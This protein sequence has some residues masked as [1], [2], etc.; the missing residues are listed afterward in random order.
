MKPKLF[1]SHAWE[2]E[3]DFVEPLATALRKEGFD[4]WYDKFSLKLGDSLLEKIGEGLRQADFGVVV[5][6]PSFFKMK[7]PRSELSGLVALETAEHKVVLPIWKDVNHDEVLGYSPVLGDRVAVLASVGIPRVV[8]EIKR[9]IGIPD[10]DKLSQSKLGTD[11]P[12]TVQ[13]AL[14]QARAICHCTATGEVMLLSSTLSGDYVYRCSR[15][16]RRQSSNLPNKFFMMVGKGLSLAATP[17]AAAHSSGDTPQR[18]GSTLS[19]TSRK[20]SFVSLPLRQPAT[21][22]LPHDGPTLRSRPKRRNFRRHQFP[23]SRKFP[24]ALVLASIA[25]QARPPTKPADSSGALKV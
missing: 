5:L 14:A 7:W 13:L 8:D 19:T 18:P 9:A 15:C 25:W 22:M 17:C 4:I 3:S 10:S 12:N 20:A 21:V 2:D 24:L 11:D 23:A 1:I 16:K 6:S